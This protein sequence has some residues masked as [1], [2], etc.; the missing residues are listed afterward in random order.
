MKKPVAS[1]C[2]YTS[3]NPH[4]RQISN[5]N[6]VLFYDFMNALPEPYCSRLQE[7]VQGQYDTE[8][9]LANGETVKGKVTNIIKNV[10]YG[11]KVYGIHFHTDLMQL[12]TDVYLD[13]IKDYMLMALASQTGK[14]S[15]MRE[16]IDEDD[17]G[18]VTK[19]ANYLEIEDK[20]RMKLKEMF[21][22]LQADLEEYEQI[23]KGDT[24]GIS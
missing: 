14:E 13:M 22:R 4:N 6:R 7:A 5:E 16:V 10:T 3:R 12:M 18:G 1:N 24:G 15:K 19:Y 20:K 8:Y 11:D 17:L 9:K 21:V 2:G 23:G